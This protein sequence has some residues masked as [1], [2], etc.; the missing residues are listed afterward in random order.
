MLA[1]SYQLLAQCLKLKDVRC[2]FFTDS[3]VTWHRLRADRN[4]LEQYVVTRVNRIN[5]LTSVDDWYYIKSEDN[6]ADIV[7]RGMSLKLLRAS[8]LWFKGPSVDT[9]VATEAQT[10]QLVC[11]FAAITAAATT[12]DDT[13]LMER[14]FSK[15]SYRTLRWFYF[16]MVRFMNRYVDLPKRHQ[17]THQQD[18]SLEFIAELRLWQQMQAV[19]LSEELPFLLAGKPVPSTSPLHKV[20]LYLDQYKLVRL[21]RRL[22]ESSLSYEVKYPLVLRDHPVCRMVS[23]QTK[24]FLH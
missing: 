4:K 18:Q 21:N 11:S 24:S 10:S 8:S 2:R 3:Q 22:D 13:E 5:E 6:P 12:V 15:T 9:I 20:E 14:L 23:P 17:E 7:S 16:R 19:T 1:E